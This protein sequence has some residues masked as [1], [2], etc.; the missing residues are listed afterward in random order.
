MPK[1]LPVKQKVNTIFFLYVFWNTDKEQCISQFMFDTSRD[2][3]STLALTCLMRNSTTDKFS[4]SSGPDGENG[5]SWLQLKS[6]TFIWKVEIVKMAMHGKLLPFTAAAAAGKTYL[7]CTE[8]SFSSESLEWC[9]QPLKLN[10]FPASS[11]LVSL[12]CK[13]RISA[14]FFNSKLIFKSSN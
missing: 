6:E 8:K 11:S 5:E 2:P 7:R 10:L 1:H 14:F 12:D 3:T 4:T 9:H 13:Y